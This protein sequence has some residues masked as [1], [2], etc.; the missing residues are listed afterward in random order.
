[1]TLWQ[2]WVQKPQA[3]LLRKLFF[4]VHLWVGIAIGLYIVLLSVTGSAL[5]FR[6]ELD[7]AFRPQV[8]PFDKSQPVLSKD[9]LA[10]AASRRYPGFAVERVGD[11]QRR[12]ALVRVVMRGGEG[13]VKNPRRDN[14]ADHFPL[15]AFIHKTNPKK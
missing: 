14:P 9:Q 3:L 15:G 6:R 5:V 8:V 11:P 12:T 10:D 7:R 13:Q 2:R 1:M 4:Q